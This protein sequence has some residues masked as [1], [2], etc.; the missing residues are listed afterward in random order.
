MNE[1]EHWITSQLRQNAI[2]IACIIFVGV[3][4]FQG[5]DKDLQHSVNDLVGEVSR[6]N[7][8]LDS[9]DTQLRDRR[10]FMGCTT[11]AMD[12]IADK[13]GVSLPCDLVVPEG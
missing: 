4:T 9:I 11:R 1:N 5:A 8:R 13:V 7:K 12:K 6:T 3:T 10:G 2:P